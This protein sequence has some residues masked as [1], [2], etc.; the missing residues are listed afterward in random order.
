MP[1]PHMDLAASRAKAAPPDMLP[2]TII[3][4]NCSLVPSILEPNG[5]F[6]DDGKHPDGVTLIS[7]KE[8]R[9]LVW[10]TTCS[11]I[12][13]TFNIHHAVREARAVVEEAEKLKKSK[14]EELTHTL[15]CSSFSED[16]WCLWSW[17]LLPFSWHRESHLILH[18]RYLHFIQLLQQVFMAIQRG[19]AAAVLCSSPAL[20][21]DSFDFK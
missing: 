19:N 7:W 12:F 16:V 14:Y 8:L 5:L 11:N 10:D 4:V 21:F 20:S 15:F 17:H 18:E 2:S 9:S 13:A 3:I 1:L 6:W